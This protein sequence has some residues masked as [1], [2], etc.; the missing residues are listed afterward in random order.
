L[1]YFLELPKGK[2]VVHF[3]QTDMFRAKE[4]L[5]DHACIMGNVPSSLL[6]VGSPQDVEEYCA[7]LIKFCGKG[8][9]FIL[10]NG[11][12]IDEA[13]PENVKAMA[14]SPEEPTPGRVT[15]P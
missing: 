6:Q 5:K 11:S 1:E 2:I 14:K 7:K 8:G 15:L 9:G 10:T 12:S 4:I 3:D 13:K